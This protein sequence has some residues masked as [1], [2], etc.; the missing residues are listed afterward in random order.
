ME[1]KVSKDEEKIVNLS[2][3]MYKRESDN[4]SFEKLMNEQNANKRKMEKQ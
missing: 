2:E 1:T 3:D 4:G